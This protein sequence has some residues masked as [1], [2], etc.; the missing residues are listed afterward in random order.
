LQQL[1]LARL[2]L[3]AILGLFGRDVAVLDDE[4]PTRPK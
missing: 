1:E 3:D 2:T 4:E